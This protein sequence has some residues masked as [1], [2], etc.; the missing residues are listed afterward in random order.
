[1]SET[2][3]EIMANIGN[4]DYAEGFHNTSDHDSN[5]MIP[6]DH[7]TDRMTPPDHDTNRMTLEFHTNLLTFH[8]DRHYESILNVSGSWHSTRLITSKIFYQV[9]TQYKD[10]THNNIQNLLLD[11]DTRYY[12][13]DNEVL[14]MF[15]RHK[16][17]DKQMELNTTTGSDKKHTRHTS[18]IIQDLTGTVGHPAWLLEHIDS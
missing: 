7:D 18:Q 11:H 10:F 2:T 16:I 9:S 13:L 6:S 3:R 15:H 1:M 17:I 12:S 5:R 14:K 8:F 4:K